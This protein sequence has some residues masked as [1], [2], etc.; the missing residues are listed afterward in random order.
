MTDNLPELRDI[1]L[2]THDVSIWPPAAGWY[3]L[4]ITIILLFVTYKAIIRLHHKSA[5]FYAK[6]LMQTTAAQDNIVA[7]AQMSEILRR[8]C[9]HRYS[10]AVALNGQDWVEFLNSKSEFKLDDKTAKLLL[11]APYIPFESTM[12]AAQ[13]VQNLRRFCLAWIGENL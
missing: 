13:D 1:H 10:E 11:N 9:V 5:K 7:A 12:F 6:Y 2:P 4:I 8:I 3:W